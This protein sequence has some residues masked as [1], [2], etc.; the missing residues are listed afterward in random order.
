MKTIKV[1]STFL[2]ALMAFSTLSLA[3]SAR[4]IDVDA[5]EVL[6]QFYHDVPGGKKFLE[7][8]KA[9]V[10]FPDINEAGFFFGG[11]Y[12][13]GVLRVNGKSKSYHSI[14]A[15][16]VGMQMGVQNYSLVLAFTSDE[17]LKNFIL[18]DD[19]WESDFS[20]KIVMAEWT[21]DDDDVDEVDYG[22]STV[23]FAYDSTG[24]LGKLSLEGTK[25]ERINPD[26]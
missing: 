1:I 10:I 9:Y 5:N 24:M 14:T 23:G 17:A 7:K 2:I 12:G 15:L 20:S 11:K 13:E 26:D 8:A 22:T 4:E 25:F 18:D 3:N 6:Q 19:D 16:S 21:T